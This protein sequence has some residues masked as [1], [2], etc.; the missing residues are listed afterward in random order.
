MYPYRK[1]AVWRDAH[2]FAL[3]CYAQALAIP[4]RSLRWQVQRSAQSI[5]ANLAEGAGSQSQAEL[6]RYVG[7]A[8]ASA[9][10]TDYHLLFAC[11][12]GLL[13]AP[14]AEALTSELD[15]VTAQLSAFLRAIRRNAKR[16]TA[17]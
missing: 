10:E 13:P 7:I 4:D 12:A 9:K 15:H 1:L 5:P 6:G 16:R 2:A 17:P 14:V 3:R 11:D 8:L